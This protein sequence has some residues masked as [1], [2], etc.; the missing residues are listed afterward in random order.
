VKT[1]VTIKAEDSTLEC[2][3]GTDTAGCC[4]WGRGAIQTTGPSNMGD[5]QKKVV[6]ELSDSDFDDIDLCDNP[7]KMCKN[8]KLKWLG[9]IHFWASVV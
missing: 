6:D 8:D 7:G 3:K 9:A 5:L 1:D 4:W 2:T